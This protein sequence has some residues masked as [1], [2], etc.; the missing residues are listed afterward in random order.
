MKKKDI[1][2]TIESI[3]LSTASS[4]PIFS[5]IGTGW[6]QWKN[7]QQEKNIKELISNLVVNLKRVEDKID[8]HLLQSSET[9]ELIEQT[10]MKVRNI[11]DFDKI[12]FYSIIISNSLVSNFPIIDYRDIVFE[13]VDK[14]DIFH[15]RLLI[16]LDLRT[17]ITISDN[18]NERT[19]YH[20]RVDEILA[21]FILYH[22]FDYIYTNLDYLKSLGLIR[23]NGNFR[24]PQMTF[25]LSNLGYNLLKYI[26]SND[27]LSEE[28]LEYSDY[29]P[30]AKDLLRELSN[31]G[32]KC[33]GSLDDFMKLCKEE[34][35][36]ASYRKTYEGL[37]TKDARIGTMVIDYLKQL[38]R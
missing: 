16:A 4:F 21:Y 18:F 13:M 22:D 12:N 20:M 8:L 10:C 27:L 2:Y 14:I 23:D 33:D 3:I 19:Y 28:L 29:R 15:L 37:K 9:K 26:T 11:S 25:G 32:F 5:S 31:K 17:R 7:Y 24:V 35:L 30:E 6:S 36:E 38:D 34:N 1:A